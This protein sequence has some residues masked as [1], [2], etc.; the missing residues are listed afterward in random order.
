MSFA[1]HNHMIERANAEI[2]A[3]RAA[4]HQA[5]GRIMAQGVEIEIVRMGW[6]E[7]EVSYLIIPYQEKAA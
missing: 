1:A 7:P 3:I 4:G 5:N 2:D 6:R